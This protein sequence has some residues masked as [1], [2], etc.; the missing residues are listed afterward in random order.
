MREERLDD[1]FDVVGR[2][3][4]GYEEKETEGQ[5]DAGMV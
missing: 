3:W 5:W 4:K 2:C 1:Q